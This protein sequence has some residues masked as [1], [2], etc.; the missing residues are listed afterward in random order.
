MTSN[1]FN[2]FI[3]IFV[4][5]LNPY[6]LEQTCDWLVN[7]NLNTHW[8]KTACEEYHP[9]HGQNAKKIAVFSLKKGNNLK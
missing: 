6:P 7:L 9:F 2:Y 3:K 5:I 1:E 4:E 8:L